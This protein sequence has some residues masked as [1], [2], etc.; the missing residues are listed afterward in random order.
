MM[1]RM[2][3]WRGGIR[4]RWT[5]AAYKAGLVGIGALAALSLGVG[6]ASGLSPTMFA[7]VS[8]GIVLVHAT[9]S[10][11]EVSGTG[12][13]IGDGVVMTANHV[14][15]GCSNVR[16]HTPAGAWIAVTSWQPWNEADS[17]D[18]DIATL[19]LAHTTYGHVFRFRT[20]QIPLR[21]SVSMLG[22][23]LGADIAL[24][25]G[26]VIL[27]AKRQ[28]FVRLLGGE[29]DSGA[30]L[31]DDAGLVVA[32]LQNGYGRTDVLGQ[33]TA[34][35]VSGYDFSSRWAAWRTALCKAYPNG[36]I[37]D[38]AGV[39]TAGVDKATT[40]ASAAHSGNTWYWTPGEC[41]SVLARGVETGDSRT[42]YPSRSYCVGTAG[43]AWETAQTQRLYTTF[44]A[45]MRSYDGVVRTMTLRATG[46]DTFSGQK[47]VLRSTSMSE[48]QFDS[49]DGTINKAAAGVIAKQGCRSG[50][51]G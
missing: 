15:K 39:G 51:F 19:E 1:A 10:G 34:G 20:G 26:K 7:T 27:R 16:V 17:S 22:H 21:G 8:T 9:C 40:F 2:G 29:G 14:V 3:G 47:L 24:T 13:L 43:C 48:A 45:I 35:L 11:G 23:P 50:V 41:K 4:R 31:V 30:P 33:R 46:R 36:G 5:Q 32:I 38:C 25:Q 18:V 6:S 28:I 12:F 49:L 42:F 37:P 44:Y